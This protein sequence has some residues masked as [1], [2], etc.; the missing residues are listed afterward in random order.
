MRRKRLPNR[1]VSLVLAALLAM[2]GAIF[3]SAIADDSPGPAERSGIDEP[4]S[5][6]SP[7]SLT[8]AGPI[9]VADMVVA[10]IDSA[11]VPSTSAGTIRDLAVREGADVTRGQLLAQLDDSEARL[12]HRRAEADWRIAEALAAASGP[13]D[14]ARQDLTLAGQS[15]EKQT[16][17]VEMA[18]RRADSDIRVQAAKK[19]MKVA[20]ND[21]RRAT[22][23][24]ER[25]SDAVSQSEVDGLALAHERAMLEAQ[26]AELERQLDAL[27]AEVERQTA[28]GSETSV[29]RA[30]MELKQA[31]FDQNV[32]RLRADAIHTEVDKT[33]LDVERH[34]IVSPLGGVVAEVLR[35][36]GEWVQ[37]GDT[38]ARVVRLDRLRAEGFLA[39]SQAIPLAQILADF[40][41]RGEQDEA[42]PVSVTLTATVAAGQ[43]IRR[44]GVI[45]FISP[46]VD[47][48]NDEVRFW[49]EFDNPDGSILPGMRMSMRLEISQ[50]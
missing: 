26:Q 44:E 35:K 11:A 40:R 46:E 33:R 27:T 4:Q 17:L 36:P 10:A 16:M 12:L 41:R 19:A 2:P 29:L 47:A 15:R 1:L 30:E 25:F 43:T 21:L 39:S 48:I 8:I 20:E 6:S 5:P 22:Q 9:E 7:A 37:P 3:T 14:L 31:E 18:L 49:V 23:A 13:T 42:T 32:L 45:G 38:V 24:R 50:P 28:E 34:T